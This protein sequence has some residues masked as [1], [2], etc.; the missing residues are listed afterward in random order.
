MN[1]VLIDHP[2]LTDSTNLHTQNQT[3][4]ALLQQGRLIEVIHCD[5]HWVGNCYQ[6]RVNKVSAQ[7]IFV[8]MGQ[9]LP[10]FLQN[11]SGMPTLK[12]GDYVKVQVKRNPAPA[13]KKGPLLTLL[14]GPEPVSA[15]AIGLL[16]RPAV[17]EHVQALS[18]HRLDKL[19]TNNQDLAAE[20]A[21]QFPHI[22]LVF[23]DDPFIAYEI[24]SQLPISSKVWL[25]SG[26]YLFIE[27][28]RACTVIDINT[29]KNTHKKKDVIHQTNTEAMAEIAYQLRLRNLSGII[30]ID[31]INHPDK[32]ANQQ[33]VKQLKT[34]TATDRAQTQVM[35]LTRLGLL[36]MTR[37]KV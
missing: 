33:L 12:Q 21:N 26:G 28:T 5:T 16:S 37:Q 18:P 20:L 11:K 10:G 29:G 36:E 22:P 3:K 32:Q 6:G 34:L 24:P 14:S 1:I 31:L 13:E 23:S 25:K 7:F 8:D 30:I 35:G 17:A 15:Q 19:V 2:Y 4:L 27:T 9:V